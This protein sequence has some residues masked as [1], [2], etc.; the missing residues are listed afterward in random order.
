MDAKASLDINMI[1]LKWLVIVRKVLAPFPFSERNKIWQTY[2]RALQDRLRCVTRRL[3]PRHKMYPSLYTARHMFA[4]AVKGS[5]STVE[6]AAM[7]G[8][9]SSATATQHYARPPKGEKKMPNVELPMPHLRDISR[10]NVKVQL[11]YKLK[12]KAP[13][14]SV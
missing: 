10:V 5:Y 7:M 11:F 14:N 13:R 12:Y 6:V 8:H 9:A 4:A 2:C 1:L 3:W